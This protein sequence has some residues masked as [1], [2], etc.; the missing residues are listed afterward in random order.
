MWQFS[1]FFLD[2]SCE[3]SPDYNEQWRN[4][5][6]DSGLAHSAICVFI[7]FFFFCNIQHNV[8]LGLDGTSTGQV[9]IT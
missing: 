7:F 3:F 2:G 4:S 6:L 8:R 9:L 5:I 1:T